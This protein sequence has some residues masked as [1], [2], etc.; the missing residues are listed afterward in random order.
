MTRGFHTF[1][2]KMIIKKRNRN[3]ATEVLL[4][5][6]L[7]YTEIHQFVSQLDALISEVVDSTIILN[8]E[9]LELI[10]SSGLG[11]LMKQNDKFKS[12]GKN[13]IYFGFT[14]NVESILKIARL[15]AFLT[16]ITKDEIDQKYP[17]LDMDE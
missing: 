8:M 12:A 17:L 7:M 1:L 3:G 11:S 14:Q 4:Q 15:E 9:M 16:I 6:K 10:D 5:G 2:E 13:L